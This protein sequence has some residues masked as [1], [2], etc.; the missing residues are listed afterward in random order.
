MGSPWS[1]Q[2][3][4]PSEHDCWGGEGGNGG[5]IGRGTPI[6]WE[7]GEDRGMLAWKP[8]KRITFEM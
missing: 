1:C 7:G 3:W 2:D 4:T 6:E 5:R 8:G